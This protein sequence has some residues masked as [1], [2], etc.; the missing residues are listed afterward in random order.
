M[1]TTVGT[2]EKSTGAAQEMLTCSNIGCFLASRRIPY[3]AGGLMWSLADLHH[4]NLQ[5]IKH[6]FHSK[7]KTFWPTQGHVKSH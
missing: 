5:Y 6:H 3:P 4:E 1:A 2:P 7:F